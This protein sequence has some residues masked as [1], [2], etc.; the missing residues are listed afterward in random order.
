MAAVKK[1]FRLNFVGD[2]ML[3]RLIDQL[4]PIHVNAPSEAQHV[5]QFIKD[6]P[7]LKDYNHKSP[8][9][10]TL[11]LFEQS[12]LNLVNL[13]TS[14][15][16]NDEPWP[17]KTFNYRMHPHNIAALREASIDYATLANNHT[18]DFGEKGLVETVRTL[19]GAKIA[20]AGAGESAGE[21]TAPAT[22]DLPS[23][24]YS[25]SKEGDEEAAE[26]NFR[27]H[28]YAA[29]D[30]P[31]DWKEISNFHLIDYSAQTKQRLKQ[32]LNDSHSN[33]PAP[34]LKVFSVHWGPN[35][36]WQP[37]T[38]ITAMAHFLIEECDVDIVHGHSSHHIQGV[39]TYKGRLII[40]GCGD[41]VDD[42][43]LN[44]E[45]RN[46]LSAVWRV[47]VKHQG[48]WHNEMEQ[49]KK[50]RRL[51]IER[52]EIFPTKITRFQAQR[53][54]RRD[55]DFEWVKDK[56]TELSGELGTVVEKSLGDDGQIVISL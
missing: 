19:K 1:S 32:L 35:Y 3:G 39:E 55:K 51:S 30:H 48:N 17:E 22:L 8:W 18:L 9:G 38:A 43:A 44:S 4:L 6:S 56:L 11:S 2:V 34:D 54:R 28:V 25:G 31:R 36:T 42:Y 24:R 47:V 37:V 15:T 5:Q 27:V 53:I 7:A 41:F 16:T 46:D 45:Y 52:L 10:D 29:S 21:E 26:T 33:R 20:F 13:E 40:Y 12:H 50:G 49:T 14:A 23:H